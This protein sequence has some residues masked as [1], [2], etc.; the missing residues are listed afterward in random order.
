MNELTGVSG[1]VLDYINNHLAKDH[2]TAARI[3]QAYANNELQR[4]KELIEQNAKD[5][6]Q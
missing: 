4:V 1:L 6:D 5:S 3:V 2:P